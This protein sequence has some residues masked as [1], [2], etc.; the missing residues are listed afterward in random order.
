MI[1]AA[2]AGKEIAVTV[3][4]KVGVL[5]DISKLLA[6]RGLNVEAVA[7]YIVDSR[8]TIMVVASDSLRAVE[9]LQKGGYKS[10]KQNDII[11]VDLE[12][13]PGALKSISSKLAAEG[14][15]LK[16]VYGTTCPEGCPARLVISTTDNEK[17]LVILSKK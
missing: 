6:D 16:Y 9:A 15:D 2:N 8:A 5:A 11:L 12:N 1:K 10:A 4:N 14:V 7:G 3:V 13:K 17:A